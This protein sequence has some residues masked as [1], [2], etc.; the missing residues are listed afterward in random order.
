MWL[1]ATVRPKIN[2]TAARAV[3]AYFSAVC[4]IDDDVSYD[5]I[6]ISWCW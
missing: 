2:I 5:D 1:V 3:K 6:V 4:Y